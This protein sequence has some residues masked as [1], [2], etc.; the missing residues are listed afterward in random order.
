MFL[1]QAFTV[2]VSMVAAL[3]WMSAAFGRTV[4]WPLARNEDSDAGRSSGTPGQMER[5]GGFVCRRSS[6]IAGHRLHDPTWVVRLDRL[7]IDHANA[8]SPLPRTVDSR[9]I[10]RP[11]IHRP[12]RQ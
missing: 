10:S 5:L 11:R 2:I 6:R 8:R 9:G 1:A 12:R 7:S 3:F 4:E